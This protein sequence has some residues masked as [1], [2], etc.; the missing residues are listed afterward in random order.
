MPEISRFFGIT[1]QMYYNGYEPAHFHV[2]YSGQKALI[3]IDTGALLRG[4]LLPRALGLG[5][6]VGSVASRRV[7][8][9]LN[10]A[11]SEAALKPIPPLE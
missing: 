2:C 6:R 7:A 3:A 8:G 9:G 4:Y 5:D 10:L 1:V 11:R